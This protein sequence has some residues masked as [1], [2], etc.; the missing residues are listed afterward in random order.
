MTKNHLVNY[1]QISPKSIYY[2]YNK[3]KELTLS[4]ELS[5][6]LEKDGFLVNKTY[7]L[8]L[9]GALIDFKVNC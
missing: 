8:I 6:H 4:Q 2:F 1:Y 7:Y 3:E 5:E 9:N